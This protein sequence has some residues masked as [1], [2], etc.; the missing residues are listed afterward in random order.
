MKRNEKQT[1]EYLAKLKQLEEPEDQKKERQ[2]K[3]KAKIEAIRARK[4]REEYDRIIR[5]LKSEKSKEKTVSGMFDLTAEIDAFKQQASD[6]TKSGEGLS[7][8]RFIMTYGFGFIT[9]LFM[10]FLSGFSLGFYALE[11]NF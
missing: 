4:A 2:A 3:V 11:W 1:K 9:M 7:D 8:I 6:A 10:G 5:P